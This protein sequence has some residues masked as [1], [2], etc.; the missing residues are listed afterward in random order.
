ML[1]LD[2]LDWQA[3]RDKGL[4]AD[5]SE[6]VDLST[7]QSNLVDPFREQGGV[8]VLPA[9]FSVPVLCGAPEDLAG[10]DNLDALADYLLQLPPAPPGTTPAPGIMSR[11]NSPTAWGL[12]AWNSCWILCWAAAPPP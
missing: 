8:F 7:L 11:W 2:G 6:W 10:L 9:R 3:Y 4:L 5:L 1:I 12:S